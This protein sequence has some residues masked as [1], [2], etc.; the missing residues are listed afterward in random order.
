MPV[1]TCMCVCKRACMCLRLSVSA[2]ACVSPCLCVIFTN[3]T[4]ID[5]FVA[6]VLIAYRTSICN[7]G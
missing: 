1:H 4:P 3:T 5:A 2:S 7:A 6:V